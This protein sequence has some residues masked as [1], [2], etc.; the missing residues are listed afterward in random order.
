MSFT[1]SICVDQGI[2]HCRLYDVEKNCKI[3]CPML[4]LNSLNSIQA[5]LDVNLKD[6]NDYKIVLLKFFKNMFFYENSKTTP[7]YMNV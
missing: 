4:D 3:G 1:R 7:S 6:V 2:V 5:S